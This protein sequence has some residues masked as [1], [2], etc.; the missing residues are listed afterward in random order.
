M[1]SNMHTAFCRALLSDFTTV[2]T[3]PFYP[4]TLVYVS[5]V[6]LPT[7]RQASGCCRVVVSFLSIPIGCSLS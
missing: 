2:T 4:K 5:R 3:T 1:Q 7:E 6:M